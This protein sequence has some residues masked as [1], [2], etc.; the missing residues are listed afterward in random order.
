MPAEAMLREKARAA[1][2]NGKLLRA[3]PN[4]TFLAGA[5]TGA[6]CAV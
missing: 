1:M 5:G 3:T 4:R 6:A 2:L